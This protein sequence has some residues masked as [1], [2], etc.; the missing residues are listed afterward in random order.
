MLLCFSCRQ[1]ASSQ[2]VDLSYKEAYERPTW[3]ERTTRRIIEPLI[4][5]C[6]FFFFPLKYLLFS[7][8]GFD[9]TEIPL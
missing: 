3:A 4:F 9:P 7:E 5:E 1:K 8:Q 6:R 2:A